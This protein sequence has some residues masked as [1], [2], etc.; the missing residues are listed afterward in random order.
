[1]AEHGRGG[2]GDGTVPLRNQKAAARVRFRTGVI[3]VMLPQGLLNLMDGLSALGA[4]LALPE[5]DKSLATH[6]ALN[7]GVSFCA[8]AKYLHLV[9]S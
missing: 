6:A 3:A 4:R 1:M 7:L 8:L 5:H 2:V 9:T